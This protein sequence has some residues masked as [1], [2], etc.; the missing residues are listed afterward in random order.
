[1]LACSQ[2]GN[3]ALL[4]ADVSSSAARY[5]QRVTMLRDAM[6]YSGVPESNQDRTEAYFDRLIGYNHPG[7]C[8]ACTYHGTVV[9]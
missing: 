1:M 6:R 9:L 3:M 2:V 5:Q 8:S 4:V 7:R